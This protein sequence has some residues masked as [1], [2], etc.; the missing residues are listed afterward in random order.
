MNS[1]LAISRMIAEG[2]NDH[3]VMALSGHSSTRMLE[4]YTHPTQ[5]HKIGALE[6]IG[7][8]LD[9]TIARTSPCTRKTRE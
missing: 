6:S 5:E 9:A 4:R 8:A 3:T 2:H 1:Q 7:Q